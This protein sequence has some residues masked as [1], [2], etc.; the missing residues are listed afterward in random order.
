MHQSV[1]EKEHLQD[2]FCLYATWVEFQLIT[3]VQAL[4]VD[5]SSIAQSSSL[6]HDGGEEEEKALI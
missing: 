1:A 5:S 3:E 2:S 4:H 6:S